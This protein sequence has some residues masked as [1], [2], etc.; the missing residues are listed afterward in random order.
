LSGLPG[1]SVLLDAVLSGAAPS[2][3]HCRELTDDFGMIQFAKGR[4]P[5]RASGYCVDDNARALLAAVLA[6][7]LKEDLRDAQAVGDTAVRFLEFCQRPDGQFHN[8]VDIDRK[9]MDDVGSPDSLGRAIWSLGVA[10]RCAPDEAWRA[11]AVRMLERSM[12]HVGSLQPLRPR[13][14]ALLGLAA[15]LDP[16]KAALLPPVAGPLPGRLND[17]ARSLLDQH[18][19]ALTDLFQRHASPPWRWWEDELTWGNARLPEALLRAALATGNETHRQTGMAALE[20]LASITHPQTIF[21]PIGNKG[22]YE[23][24][25]ERARYDQQPIEA[26]AMADL[27]L[28]AEQSSADRRYHEKALEAFAWFVGLN[29]DKLVVARPEFGG[30]CDGLKPGKLNEN[31]GAESTL[32]YVQSHA[33]V[34]IAAAKHRPSL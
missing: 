15:L 33:A 6:L 1:A 26:C 13:A 20:F 21:E 3:T 10:A 5:D 8:L 30:C 14:Y 34:A 19:E 29:S 24:G 23:K 2:F 16:L 27:W 11:A 31:M 22:W 32:S 17:Q 4:A 12:V 25:G 9:F 18:A 7:H 28:A